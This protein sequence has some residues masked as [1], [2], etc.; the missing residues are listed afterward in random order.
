MVD[1]L[2][3]SLPLCSEYNMQKQSLTVLQKQMVLMLL[4]RKGRSKRRK[5]FQIV[6]FIYVLVY[7]LQYNC[8][9][10]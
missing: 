3:L 8:L 7:T 9:L 2:L 1:N 6:D 4:K 10:R 5:V